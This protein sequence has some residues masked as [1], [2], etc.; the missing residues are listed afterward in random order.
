MEPLPCTI[1][2]STQGGKAKAC[3][4]RTARIMRDTANSCKHTTSN[5]T[6][7]VYSLPEGCYGSSFDDYGADEFFK[8]GKGSASKSNIHEG[9][10]S[11]LIIIFISTTGD[12]EQCD[13]IKDTWRKLLRRSVP[14]DQFQHLQFAM[15]CLGDRAYGPS[16]FCAAGRKLAARMVQLGAQPFCDLGYGDDGTP[17]GGVFHDLDGWLENVL[18]NQMFGKRDVVMEDVSPGAGLRLPQTPY[19]AKLTGMS[20]AKGLH[21]G[22]E[23]EWQKKQYGAHYGRFLAASC[24][25]TSYHYNADNGRRISGSEDM[26]LL[27]D[28]LGGRPLVA[29]VLSNDKIT[30]EDW[31]QDT[32]HVRLHVVTSD[33]SSTTTTSAQQDTMILPYKAGDIATVMPYNPKATVARFISCLP[34][35][36]RK[37][38]DDPLEISTRITSSTQYSTA[39]TPWPK[40]ATLRG[41]LTYCAD[42]CSLPER[43]DL[44]AL[45]FYCNPNHPVGLDQRKKLLSLSETS[46]AALYGDYI[47]RE[48]RNWSDI[49]FDFDSIQFESNTGD[50]TNGKSTNFVPLT[51]GHLLM[52]LSPI[53]PR[54]FSIAS[55]PSGLSDGIEVN[56]NERGYTLRNGKFGFDMELCVAVVKGKTR[57]GRQ[58]QGLC[59]VYFSY[60]KPTSRQ[61]VHIWIRPGSFG[62]LPLQVDERGEFETPVMCVG[63]GTGVAP[64]RSLLQEREAARKMSLS[65]VE[66]PPTSVP[67]SKNI[68]VLGCRKSSMDFY[69]KK[70][71]EEMKLKGDLR[72]L[73]A[74]SQ[75]QEHKLYVQKILREADEGTLIAKHILENNGCIYIA[76]GAKMARAVKDEIVES[77]GNILPTGE[78]GAKILLY[79]L[80]RAGKFSVEAWS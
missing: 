6:R 8:L 79:K 21:N 19:Y 46:D 26:P 72:L 43:E 3:A 25:A 13:D 70:E 45:S 33:A 66:L 60:L 74:F 36:I 41:I 31:V 62:K 47:L 23:I 49:L 50:E 2:W 24:P 37:I 18:L 78:K 32:R 55:A 35:S 11:R 61:D 58:Y 16:A 69:Y 71:W 27:D 39:Y 67:Q 28:P 42:I 1:L 80:Q 20:N 5:S 52:I 73:T 7:A 30:S 44:R 51:I 57:Y 56:T 68:L 76:G 15:F 59:S 4:R 34:A 54:H 53:M 77:L 40:E 65:S 14:S 75:D 10:S 64:L 22:N 9:G 29:S 48:K 38:V 17:N 12:A 63:A